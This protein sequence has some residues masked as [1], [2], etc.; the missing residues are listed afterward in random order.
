MKTLCLILLS[1]LFLLYSC[2]EKQDPYLN[3]NS[4]CYDLFDDSTAWDAYIEE[5]G[6]CELF[7]REYNSMCFR[8]YI[9]GFY[10]FEWPDGCRQGSEV[11]MVVRGEGDGLDVG[12][13]HSSPPKRQF[14][15]NHISAWSYGEVYKILP[16]SFSEDGTLISDTCMS[17]ETLY[18]VIE[19][20]KIT[21]DLSD[22]YDELGYPEKPSFQVDKIGSFS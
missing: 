3:L 4:K 9:S 13:Y 20:E 7:L 5:C 16:T 6:G 19:F 10:L 11:L 14:V 12:F 18:G 15:D 17:N 8:R 22:S 2:E 21:F 1:S